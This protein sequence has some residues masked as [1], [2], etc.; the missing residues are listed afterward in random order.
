MI[1]QIFFPPAATAAITILVLSGTASA[2]DA[3]AVDYPPKPDS[4]FG[5]TH[6][7]QVS[8]IQVPKDPA[9]TGPN[10]PKKLVNDYS[11]VDRDIDDMKSAGVEVVRYGL[12]WNKFPD[13]T[14][15]KA[16]ENGVPS[17]RREPL[18]V[19][20]HIVCKLRAAGIKVQMTIGRPPEYFL[21]KTPTDWSECSDTNKKSIT[22]YL[23]D[24]KSCSNMAF[25][26]PVAGR[27]CP[28]DR[29]FLEE[30]R[31]FLEAAVS[32]YGA[33]V[34]SWEIW[35]EPNNCI[36]W[37]GTALEYGRL[38]GTALRLFSEPR[39]EGL[40]YTVIAPS[41]ACLGF[42]DQP[43]NREF[44]ATALEKAKALSPIAVSWGVSD[45]PYRSSYGPDT[46]YTNQKQW[47][48]TTT[49]I[50]EINVV[51]E[52]LDF[53]AAKQIFVTEVGY[54]SAKV[55]GIAAD[56]PTP[57]EATQA[58]HLV[59]TYIE[60]YANPA[61]KRV[62]WFHW[63][64][65]V[66]GAEAFGLKSDLATGKASLSAYTNV[67]SLLKGSVFSTKSR[68]LTTVG[69]NQVLSYQFRNRAGKQCWAAWGT[70]MYEERPMP[71]DAPT[72]MP[73]INVSLSTLGIASNAVLSTSFWPQNPSSLRPGV[74][75]LLSKGAPIAVCQP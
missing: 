23:G 12:S 75:L 30:Y 33:N 71:P 73:D 31:S 63:R 15:I 8:K 24:Q 35:N 28:A 48:P 13:S 43:D 22:S 62:N 14:P 44:F 49:Q 72:F 27:S 41:S 46:K 38:V 55:S 4:F 36:S 69:N 17:D 67:A 45:H 3:P 51:R 56:D 7:F 16:C 68:K 20:D 19:T 2:A 64:E 58:G 1:R 10:D 66:Y 32:R 70:R 37:P 50:D 60:M 6:G 11:A 9:K 5:M 29:S 65:G 26:L 34:E 57:T 40:H 39:F 61:V 52:Q 25:D 53:A 21:N 74:S 54:R 42:E 59:R 18:D 47:I